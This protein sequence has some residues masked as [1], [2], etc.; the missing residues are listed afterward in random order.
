VSFAMDGN[1]QEGKWLTI[2]HKTLKWAKVNSAPPKDHFDRF[3][4]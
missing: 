4:W 1:R 3:P 2:K